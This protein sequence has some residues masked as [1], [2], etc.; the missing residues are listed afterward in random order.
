[1]WE[2]L[3]KFMQK[4]CDALE[5]LI[6]LCVGVALLVSVVL[7]VPNLI[8]VLSAQGSTDMF[9]VFLEQVFNLVVGI[10]FMKLLCKPSTDNVIEIVIF[11]VARHMIITTDSATDIFL[12]VLSIVILCVI[13]KFSRVVNEKWPHKKDALKE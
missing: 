8:E 3:R 12:S 1:M 9:L 13:R 5:L 10:E 6:A 11:L 4:T 7:S 2:K